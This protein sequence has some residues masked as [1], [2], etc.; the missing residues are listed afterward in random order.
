MLFHAGP[1]CLHTYGGTRTSTLPA[2]DGFRKTSQ[3]LPKGDPMICRD[4]IFLQLIVLPFSVG[5]RTPRK[6]PTLQSS[7]R[8]GCHAME[9]SFKTSLVPMT[10]S[11]LRWH[12]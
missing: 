7:T 12:G 10:Y 2:T 5:V 3:L 8:I 1:S 4:N 9:I 6:E 11:K